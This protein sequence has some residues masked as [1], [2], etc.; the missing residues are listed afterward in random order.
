MKQIDADGSGKIHYSEFARLLNG[1]DEIVRSTM[2]DA[3]PYG[4]IGL[5]APL[6]KSFNQLRAAQYT[7][8]DDYDGNVPEVAEMVQG[9]GSVWQQNKVGNVRRVKHQ[10]SH[11][12]IGRRKVGAPNSIG[13]QFN[14][15]GMFLLPKHDILRQMVEKLELKHSGY[16]LTKAFRKYDKNGD[17]RLDKK[18]LR[19]MLA[20]IGFEMTDRNFELL[21][22]R[23][24]LGGDGSIDLKEWWSHIVNLA[25]SGPPGATSFMQRDES[26]K[27]AQ[28]F[29]HEDH[30]GAS[31]KGVV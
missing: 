29:R 23:L 13:P 22:K 7:G 2:P 27:E 1:E 10:E 16:K 24:D 28:H 20:D 26:G 14:T 12:D 5:D 8:P 15:Y 18:E 9:N 25:V 11:S 17:G 31:K 30:D 21:M 3:A 6:P 4:A 19:A